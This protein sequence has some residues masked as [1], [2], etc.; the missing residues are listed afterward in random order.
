VR[1]M[2]SDIIR[3]AS[4]CPRYESVLYGRILFGT[5]ST[6]IGIYRLQWG[7]HING[8][9]AL[10]KLVINEYERLENVNEV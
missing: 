10:V 6:G 9:K 7:I 5:L 4:Y 2:E 1:N 3:R 8:L